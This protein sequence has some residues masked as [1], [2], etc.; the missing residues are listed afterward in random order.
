[1]HIYSHTQPCPS[2]PLLLHWLSLFPLEINCA[3]S[4]SGNF[5]RYSHC[6]RLRHLSAF[7]GL[8]SDVVSYLILRAMKIKHRLHHQYILQYKPNNFLGQ[9]ARALKLSHS[10]HPLPRTYSPAFDFLSPFR[11]GDIAPSSTNVN[12]NY[13]MRIVWGYICSGGR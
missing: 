11:L 9:S 3:N 4:T 13:C 12:H 7:I 8:V 10:T 6:Y 2:A 5:S 1:V